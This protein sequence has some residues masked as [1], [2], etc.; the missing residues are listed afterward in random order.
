VLVDD[1]KPKS[2]PTTRG[3][4]TRK[5][6]LNPKDSCKDVSS[7]RLHNRLLRPLDPRHAR[8]SLLT[9]ALCEA[10][11][12]SSAKKNDVLCVDC[13]YYYTVLLDLLGEDRDAFDKLKQ[14]FAWR[15]KKLQT[16]EY[17]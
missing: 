4:M 16:I 3:Q 10:C 2:S 15:M 14:I 1:P 17:M 5:I 8:R 12:K 6:P 11:G 13:A 7:T 9:K